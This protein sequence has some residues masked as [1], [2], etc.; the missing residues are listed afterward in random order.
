VERLA[1]KRR[2]RSKREEREWARGIMKIEIA[3]YVSSLSTHP[4]RCRFPFFKQ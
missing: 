4:K 2:E 1:G 3:L